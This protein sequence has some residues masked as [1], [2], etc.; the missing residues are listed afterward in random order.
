MNISNNKPL[1]LAAIN[2]CE[3]YTKGQKDI[4]KILVGLCIDDVVTVGTTYL[5]EKTGL[6][7]ASIYLNIKKFTQEGLIIK[8][9]KLAERQDSFQLNSEKL[10]Y[11]LQLYQNKK[12]MEND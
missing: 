10:D 7:R 8:I 2:A 6:S 12:A 4:L 5:S 11:I 9:R 3:M 1:L